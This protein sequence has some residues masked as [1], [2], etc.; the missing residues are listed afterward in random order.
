MKKITSTP[1]TLIELLVVIAIIAIL[2]AM[3][4]PA[5]N[6]A[7]ERGRTASCVNNE[8]QIGQAFMMYVSDWDGFY[9]RRGSGTAGNSWYWYHLIASYVGIQCNLKT[10]GS[11]TLADVDIKLYL[12]PS[13]SSPGLLGSNAYIA[14][15]GGTS[16]GSNHHITGGKN[17]SGVLYGIKET[18]IKYPSKK[19]LILET[20][21][22]SAID[23]N[24][25]DRFKYL[26]PS[27]GKIFSTS[28]GG[29]PIKTTGIGMNI[30]YADGHVNTEYNRIISNYAFTHG[31]PDLK[32]QH[33]L[34]GN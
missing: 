5:L 4:L 28:S 30:T 16:Y 14:G 23:S 17:I 8:K 33:W 12:C 34:P 26:H 7:R 32:E 24:N 15:K 21:G 31:E 3:L 2:A 20:A 22:Y 10:D 18:E 29:T 13:D 19:F 6:S 11:P 27:V 9:P 1:F 25:D